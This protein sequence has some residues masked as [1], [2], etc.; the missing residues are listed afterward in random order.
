MLQRFALLAPLFCLFTPH[1]TEAQYLQDY[2]A[3]TVNPGH[4]L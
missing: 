3:D 4:Y 1:V 2:L